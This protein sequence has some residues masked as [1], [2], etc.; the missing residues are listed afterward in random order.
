MACHTYRNKPVHVPQTNNYTNLHSEKHLIFFFSRNTNL[1]FQYDIKCKPVGQ[2]YFSLRNLS[3]HIIRRLSWERNKFFFTLF[4]SRA[5]KQHQFNSQTY[6]NI[7]MHNSPFVQETVQRASWGMQKSCCKVQRVLQGPGKEK[8]LRQNHFINYNKLRK[9]NG[10]MFIEKASTVQQALLCAVSD[11]FPVPR[12]STPLVEMQRLLGRSW[13]L[14]CWWRSPPWARW[15]PPSVWRSPS[16]G[17]GRHVSPG[18][19]VTVTVSAW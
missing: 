1:Y 15:A 5:L 16:L 11:V 7:S 2:Y 12:W 6:K 3:R 9:L 13:S 8:R 18:S 10:K 19:H 14:W 4:F 17:T